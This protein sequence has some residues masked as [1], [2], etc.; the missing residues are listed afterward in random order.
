MNPKFL[1]SQGNDLV[2]FFLGEILTFVKLILLRTVI[3]LAAFILSCCSSIEASSSDFSNS[4][5]E[6]YKCNIYIFEPST[7]FY[8]I[9]LERFKN[10]NKIFCFNYGLS[11]S[12]NEFLLSDE[13]EASSITKNKNGLVVKIRKFSKVFEE[14]NINKIDL[15]KVNI[16]GSEYDLIPHIIGKS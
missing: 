4:I 12:D 6:K 9:C 11:D 5:Y 2:D 1:I 8:K 7:S 13:K 16:E 3:S 14:L 10:N 15:L